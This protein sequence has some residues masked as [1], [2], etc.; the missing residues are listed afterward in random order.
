MQ[1]FIKQTRQ[2]I[3]NYLDVTKKSQSATAKEIGIS[4]ATLS[5]FINENYT[6]SN[7]EISEKIAQFLEL[8]RKRELCTPS[9]RFTEKLNNTKLV[10]NALSYIQITNNIA[11]IIGTA[12][13][14]KTTAMMHFSKEKHGVIYVQADATKKS[15]R[16]ALSLISKAIS[17]KP[18]GTASD[19]LDSLIEEFTGSGKLIIIDEAQH[20][21]ER[22][23]DTLRA[24]NDRASVGIV[25]AGTPDIIA[26]MYGKHEAELDQVHSRIGYVC[27]LNNK[28]KLEDI[29][30]VFEEFK[31]EKTIIK[32]L[33]NISSRKGG[34]RLAINLF[35]FANDLAVT[36]NEPLEIKHIEYAEKCV[37]SGGVL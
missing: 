26:R 22:S 4:T 29:E 5:Q 12:G 14:G 34:L 31:L 32:R 28:Y 36:A 1:E 27:K 2:R 30:N 15:P 8:Q 10:Y 18:C 6:G 9:P 13:S 35:K 37:G 20:L 33:Y 21:T 7:E 19:T 23:F 17:K 16:A 25:F 11:T 3:I 24:I